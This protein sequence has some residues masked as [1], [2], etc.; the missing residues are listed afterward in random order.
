MATN[1]KKGLEMNITSEIAHNKQLEEKLVASSQ[2][3]Q[4]GEIAVLIE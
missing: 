2:D 1:I 4:I 3:K